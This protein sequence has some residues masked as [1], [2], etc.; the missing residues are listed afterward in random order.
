MRAQGGLGG[1]ALWETHLAVRTRFLEDPNKTERET[2]C[3]PQTQQ[4]P[5]CQDLVPPWP[6]KAELTRDS[7]AAL[8]LYPA[9][10][11]PTSRQKDR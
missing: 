5:Q 7:V 8:G 9:L 3:L 4:G 1:E 2:H 11:R 10:P 6:E